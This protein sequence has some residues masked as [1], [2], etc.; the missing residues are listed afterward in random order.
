ML[1]KY[2]FSNRFSA[3]EAA[4]LGDIVFGTKLF[5]STVQWDSSQVSKSCVVQVK[6]Q[7]GRA[8]IVSTAAWR[9]RELNVRRSGIQ[10]ICVGITR[11]SVAVDSGSG[12]CIY[13]TNCS[14]REITGAL[15]RCTVCER[16]AVKCVCHNLSI[17]ASRQSDS[18][19]KET[20]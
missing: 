1:V 9:D 11:K 10:G 5:R 17:G 20:E 3:S 13:V 4:R 12:G 8:R 6:N 14:R 16:D 19:Y 18:G 2:L 15:R 7:E